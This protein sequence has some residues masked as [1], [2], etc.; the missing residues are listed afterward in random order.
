MSPA[1]RDQNLRVRMSSDEVRMLKQL[2][3]AM[4]LTASDVVR[5]LIRREHV[6]KFGDKLKKKR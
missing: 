1:E 5:S 4:G 3:D 6:E 2:S